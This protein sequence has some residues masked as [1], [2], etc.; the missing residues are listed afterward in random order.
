MWVCLR[1]REGGIRAILNLAHTFGHAIGTDNGVTE[2]GLQRP[3]LALGQC[4][5]RLTFLA[6]WGI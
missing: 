1:Q 5:W 4:G 3:K 2:I 6:E